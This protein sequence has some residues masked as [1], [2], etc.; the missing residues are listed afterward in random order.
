MTAV[1][2]TKNSLNTALVIKFLTH[3][4]SL[5]KN[6]THLWYEILCQLLI[7]TFVPNQ[8]IQLP[9]PSPVSPEEHGGSGLCGMLSRAGWSSRQQQWDVPT[10]SVCFPRAAH[11]WMTSWDEFSPLQGT[12]VEGVLEKAVQSWVSVLPQEVIHWLSERNMHFVRAK[13]V[14]FLPCVQSCGP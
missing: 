3:L 12:W 5:H 9:S 8:E 7:H 14:M 2:G 6:Y 4:K 1:V 11:L 10:W 13:S